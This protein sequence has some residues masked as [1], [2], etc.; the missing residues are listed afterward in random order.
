M[1]QGA[2]QVTCSLW[3]TAC[4]GRAL[5][6]LILKAGGLLNVRATGGDGSARLGDDQRPY[7]YSPPDTVVSGRRKSRALALRAAVA[8]PADGPGF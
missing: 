6:V 5:A 7:A 1:C 3:W 2:R 4:D 8:H